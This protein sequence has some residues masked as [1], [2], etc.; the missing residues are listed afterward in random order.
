MSGDDEKFDLRADIS[1]H[2][3]LKIRGLL[4]TPLNEYQ[5]PAWVQAAELFAEI[6][7]PC[8]AFPSKALRDLGVD[9]AKEAEKRGKHLAQYLPLS[10]RFFL[11]YILIFPSKVYILRESIIIEIIFYQACSSFQ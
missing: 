9:I 8:G 6:V 11:K 1:N 3:A 4:E 10:G 7:A 2:I 5:D